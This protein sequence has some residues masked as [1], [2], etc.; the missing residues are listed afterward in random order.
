MTMKC[1]ICKK[2]A[3]IETP[4]GER[5]YCDLHFSESIE[6]RVRK[7]IRINQ[8]LDLKKK[9]YLP[10][11]KTSEIKIAEDILKNIFGKNLKIENTTDLNKKNLIL[12]K[13]LD[14]E[15]SDFLESYFN[16]KHL[17]K[18]EHINPLKS[19]TQKEIVEIARI[20]KIQYKPK[21]TLK[22]L[23]ELEEKYSGTLFS[24]ARSS[25][26]INKKNKKINVN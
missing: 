2:K 12:P 11:D 26:F 24:V 13:S 17:S 21:K 8:P 4:Y 15:S 19:L 9:Y 14:E 20:M 25:D 6:K 16:N 18:N 1:A 22:M 5:H 10:K 3:T 23:E 7:D